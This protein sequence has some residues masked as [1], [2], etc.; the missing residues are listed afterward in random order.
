[1]LEGET[2]IRDYN[3]ERMIMLTDGVF[4]IALTL[5][6]FDLKPPLGW[7]GTLD[8]LWRDLS[9]EF[10]AYAMSFL[11]IA[12]YWAGHRR[13]YRRFKRA[14]GVLTV[15]NFILLGLVTLIPF[16]ASLITR[17]H[18]AGEPL[19][20]YMSLVVGIGVINA[21][22]WGY[23]AFIARDMLESKMSAPLRLLSFLILLVVPAIVATMAVIATHAEYKW[24][25][26]I[27]LALVA[28]IAVLRRVLNAKHDG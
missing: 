10:L 6:A 18:P 21:L 15:L 13:T 11:F 27:M 14:D 24:V 19:I 8:E 25:Y 12:V 28:S 26:A 20:I 5:L 4:A 7:D 16:G 23:A 22:Q 3:L 9:R 17:A 2:K 1:M